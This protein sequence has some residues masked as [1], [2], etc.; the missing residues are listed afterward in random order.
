M[1]VQDV[2]F[3]TDHMSIF[4]EKRKNDQLREGFLGFIASTNNSYCPISLTEKFLHLG[5]QEDS[6]YIFRKACHSKRGHFLRVQRLTYS[7]ALELTRNQLL[8]VGLKPKDYGMHS[9]C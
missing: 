7:R 2:M 6:S 9:M 3:S 4:V 5:R 8:A 1:K